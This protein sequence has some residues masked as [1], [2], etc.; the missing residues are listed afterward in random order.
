MRL[1]ING[2][3]FINVFICLIQNSVFCAKLVMSGFE[4]WLDRQINNSLFERFKIFRP[5]SKKTKSEIYKRVKTAIYRDMKTTPSNLGLY[6]ILRWEEMCF[7]NVHRH[8]VYYIST[9]FIFIF[10]NS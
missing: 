6:D 10:S 2:V 5:L 1:I 9:S 7:K 4:K 8:L 3:I